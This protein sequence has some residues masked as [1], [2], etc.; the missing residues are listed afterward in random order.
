M[1]DSPLVT[2]SKLLMGAGFFI[3]LIGVLTYLASRIPGFGKFPGD[4]FIQKGNFSFYFPLVTSLI[5]SLVL[6]ILV[7]L[8]RRP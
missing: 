4:V 1:N 7:N 3:M 6:T 8:F 5:V 2:V